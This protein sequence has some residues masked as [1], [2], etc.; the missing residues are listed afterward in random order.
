MSNSFPLIRSVQPASHNH[1]VD[2][3]SLVELLVAGAVGLVM[4]LAGVSLWFGNLRATNTLIAGQALRDNWARVNL[5]INA[6]ISESCAA[7]VVSGNLVLTIKDPALIPADLLATNCNDPDNTVTVTYSLSGTTLQRTGP[8][9]TNTGELNTAV[10]ATTENLVDGANF[11]PGCT[12]QFQ[13]CYTFSLTAG[14]S[15]YA[16]MVTGNTLAG[17]SRSREYLPTP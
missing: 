7:Q 13:P 17:R 5:F 8:P 11:N 15:T 1:P 4:T 12:T 2:G 10:D 14:N 9:I 6:D 3:F 16:N